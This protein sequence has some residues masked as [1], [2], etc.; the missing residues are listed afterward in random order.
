M[1]KGK[2]GKRKTNE[3]ET[4]KEEQNRE[5]FEVREYSEGMNNRQEDIRKATD[6][7]QKAGAQELMKKI[8]LGIEDHVCSRKQC[9]GVKGGEYKKSGKRDINRVSGL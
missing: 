3:E 7:K 2:G 1:G 6:K 9:R 5:M 8:D 4:G